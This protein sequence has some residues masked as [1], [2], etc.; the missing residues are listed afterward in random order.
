MTALPPRILR[1][2]ITLLLVAALP[3]GACKK[4]APEQLN[5][6]PIP[7][8]PSESDAD[9]NVPQSVE[10]LAANFSRIYFDFDQATIDT[11]SRGALDTNARIM[12]NNSD[13]KVEIQGHADERGTTDYNLALGQKRSDSVKSYLVSAGVAPSRLSS[14]SYGEEQPLD[15][16]HTEIAWS[17][18]R[19]AEFRITWGGGDL[20][21]ST[22]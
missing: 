13:I 10:E 6:A 14:I 2:G 4:K 1:L 18:N 15:M 12:L 21:G 20:Q 16:A 17:K 8:T 9:R 5:V 22:E 11:D 3:L 19:R 7:V